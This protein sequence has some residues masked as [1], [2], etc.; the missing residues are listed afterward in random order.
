MDNGKLSDNKTTW[1]LG[2]GIRY[3]TLIT[4]I[5]RVSTS[6]PRRT[7][8]TQIFYIRGSKTPRLIN[9]FHHAFVMML[10][11]DKYITGIKER[12]KIRFAKRYV[13][14]RF[15][16]SRVVITVIIKINI[17]IN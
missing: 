2:H 6:Y 14:I 12:Q 15:A 17:S 16:N 4:G 10:L 5:M 3:R 1:L 9:G 7:L 11:F 13:A 8:S